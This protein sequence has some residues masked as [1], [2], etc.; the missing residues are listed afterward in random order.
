MVL[1]LQTNSELGLLL[2]NKHHELGCYYST[3]Y[4]I[5]LFAMLIYYQSIIAKLD[6]RTTQKKEFV[7]PTKHSVSP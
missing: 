3:I 1:I 5:Q 4:W 2:S 7:A 6:H